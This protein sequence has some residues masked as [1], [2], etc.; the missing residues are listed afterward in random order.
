MDD[1]FVRIEDEV[2][3]NEPYEEILAYATKR[4]SA[5]IHHYWVSTIP[6]DKRNRAAVAAIVASVLIE[7]A[8]WFVGRGKQMDSG[9]SENPAP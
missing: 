5:H 4:V 3:A 1:F 7:H 6:L 8:R 2:V 9:I